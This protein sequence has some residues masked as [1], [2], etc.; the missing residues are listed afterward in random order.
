MEVRGGSGEDP[1]QRV[2]AGA[3]EGGSRK[4]DLTSYRPTHP[5]RGESMK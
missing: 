5:G 4:G 2:R 3:G 1:W